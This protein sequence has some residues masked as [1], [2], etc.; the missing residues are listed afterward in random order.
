MD[1]LWLMRDHTTHR[2]VRCVG[3]L[4]SSFVVFGGVF[5]FGEIVRIVRICE[6]KWLRLILSKSNLPNV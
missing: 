5:F 1:E 3:R 4:Y 6:I 2:G